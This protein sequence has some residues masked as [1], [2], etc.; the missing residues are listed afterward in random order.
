MDMPRVI[1]LTGRARAGKN[2]LAKKSQ[3]VAGRIRS[4]EAKPT[5]AIKVPSRANVS[6][7]WSR[8]SASPST[9]GMLRASAVAQAGSMSTQGT[10]CVLDLFRR[11]LLLFP[12]AGHAPGCCRSAGALRL[13]ISREPRK[14]CGYQE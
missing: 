4:S 2:I 1:G 14:K 3:A 12:L 8:A 5:S 10:S 7:A 11:P 6:G 13:S 9:V